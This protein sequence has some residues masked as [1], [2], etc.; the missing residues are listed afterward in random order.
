MFFFYLVTLII[1]VFFFIKLIL[2]FLRY[3]TEINNFILNNVLFLFIQ[4]S[5]SSGSSYASVRKCLPLHFNLTPPPPLDPYTHIV[6]ITPLLPLP[7]DCPSIS[8]PPPPPPLS[9]S[10]CC[11]GKHCPS[12]LLFRGTNDVLK[13]F[14]LNT[15]YV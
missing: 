11:G 5:E 6:I 9:I 1:L 10:Y 13:D 15:N 4:I 12:I 7:I 8:P 14:C 2:V 3:V